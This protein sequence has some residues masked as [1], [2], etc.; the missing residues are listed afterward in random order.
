M[1]TS[2]LGFIV[3]QSYFMIGAE[4]MAAFKKKKKNAILRPW[5]NPQLELRRSCSVISTV[6]YL[7]SLPVTLLAESLTNRKNRRALE[8]ISKGFW[9]AREEKDEEIERKKKHG[10]GALRL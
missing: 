6:I 3:A 8:K 4:F 7:S 5:G 10:E 1:N 2:A 9:K